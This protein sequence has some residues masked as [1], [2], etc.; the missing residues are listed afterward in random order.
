M[1][2]RTGSAPLPPG[3]S[4][5]VRRRVTAVGLGLL[6]YYAC[7][8]FTPVSWLT[9]PDWITYL[10]GPRLVDRVLGPVIL[11]GAAVL[12]WYIASQRTAL[13]LTISIPSAADVVNNVNNVNNNYNTT[14]VVLGLWLP[15]YFW[16][17]AVAEAAIL[18]AVA[19]GSVWGLTAR[20]VIVGLVVG[21]WVLGWNAMPWYR[22]QQAWAFMKD[23]VVR[24]LIMEL[25]DSAFGGG[26]GGRRRRR[27]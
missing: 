6:F 22:K 27:R 19:F 20:L 18:W 12:H 25:M 5:L 13:P 7:G 4:D 1:S 10:D 26:F 23:Y 24:L 11:L 2:Q 9:Q 21:V 15:S 8:P 17:F 16:P 3:P 14:T